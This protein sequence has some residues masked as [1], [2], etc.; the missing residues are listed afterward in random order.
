MRLR[1]FRLG[2]GVAPC[3]P[4]ANGRLPGLSKAHHEWVDRP[5]LAV[6]SCSRM[7]GNERGFNWSLQHLDSIIVEKDV[8][9]GIP[10]EDLLYR[11]R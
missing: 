7:S 4:P 10:D 6:S 11:S 2:S 8:A 5:L 1:K 9:D 3:L